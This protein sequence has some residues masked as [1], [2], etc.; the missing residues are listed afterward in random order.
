[1]RVVKHPHSNTTNENIIKGRIL[2]DTVF[3][4]V[5]QLGNTHK[6]I[7]YLENEEEGLNLPDCIFITDDPALIVLVECKN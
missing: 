3:E 7:I 4:A 1:M 2:E 5:K 6:E